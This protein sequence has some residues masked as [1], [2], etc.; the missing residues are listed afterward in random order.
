MR[1][2]P[3]PPCF[4]EVIGSKP[5]ISSRTRDQLCNNKVAEQISAVFIVEIATHSDVV[6]SEQ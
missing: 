6:E 3:Y 5:V 2:R 1:L 4:D